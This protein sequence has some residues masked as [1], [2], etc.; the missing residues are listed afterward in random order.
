M[1]V[2]IC[3][4]VTCFI[5]IARAS[6]ILFQGM[7][8]EG[9]HFI[10]TAAIANVLARKGHNITFLISNV[11]AERAHD[12]RYKHLKFETFNQTLPAS[13]I[14]EKMQNF[15]DVTLKEG[16][17]MVA[18]VMMNEFLQL[19]AQD[20]DAIF[21]DNDL[22]QRL[23]GKKLDTIVFDM[24]WPCSVLLGK[25]LNMKQVSV[26]PS[27]YQPSIAKLFGSPVNAAF[28]PAGRFNPPSPPL[29]FLQRVGN[30][31][32]VIMADIIRSKG[33]SSAYS[34]MQLKHNILPGLPVMSLF[35]EVDIA[36][37]N[38]D[39]VVEY[40]VPL[41]PYVVPVGGLTTKPAESL[42]Q[43]LEAF[44]MNSGDYGVV[45]FSLGTYINK[46]NRRI[47]EML[48][49]A[50]SKLPCKVLWKHSY[51]ENL[52]V[53]SNV[54]IQKW[55]PLNDILGHSKTRAFVYQGGNNGLYEAIYHGVPMVVLPIGADQGQVASKV[56]HK[57][58]GISAEIRTISS[59]ELAA[60]IMEVLTNQTYRK[61]I[62]KASQLFRD[63]PMTP[64]E[65]AAYWVEHVTK[66]GGKMY[67]SHS[68]GMTWIQHTTL[69]VIAAI[70][71]TTFLLSYSLI[72]CI[73][74]LIRCGFRSFNA[75]YGTLA[76]G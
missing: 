22:M 66:F 46:A 29:T 58:I 72:S 15:I 70:L 6:H 73:T 67:K 40:P 50:F 23:K 48:A 60:V 28:M 45:V 74:L 2:S 51:P 64:A 5:A 52:P 26:A 56:R 65:T 36:L 24:T 8:G 71:V 11:Y 7:Y 33:L 25:A 12:P 32:Q 31:F 3:L 54:R 76:R 68:H 4:V 17:S 27:C 39:F 69:D 21:S 16:F 1:R 62:Q 13:F 47:D 18:L 34:A 37:L 42:P 10:T 44:M 14:E 75:L 57:G 59:D 9:S 55:L 61:N 35:A 20:C 19:A 38:I 30:F 53:P 63:R 43:D 41:T 49:S